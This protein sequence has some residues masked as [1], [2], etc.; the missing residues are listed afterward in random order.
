[1]VQWSESSSGPWG[2]VPGASRFQTF[3]EMLMVLFVLVVWGNN[4][5]KEKLLI[6]GDNT[7]ALSSALNLK[8][9]GTLAAIAREIAWRQIRHGW[10]FEV[11]HVPTELNTV[12]D[13]LSRLHEPNPPRFPDAALKA[14]QRRD[15]PDFRTLWRVVTL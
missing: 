9:K 14:A 15:P 4:F 8:G 12:A 1:M 10:E 6:V 3:W 11:G 5:Q 7:G 13:A 2:A